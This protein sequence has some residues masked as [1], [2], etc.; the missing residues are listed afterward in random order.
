MSM[1]KTTFLLLVPFLGACGPLSSRPGEDFRITTNTSELEFFQHVGPRELEFQVSGCDDFSTEV[2]SPGVAPRPVEPRALGDGRFVASLPI[3]SL[4]SPNGYCAYS[5]ERPYHTGVQLRVTCRQDGRVQA[6]SLGVKYVPAW[7]MTYR[8]RGPVDAVFGSG[9]SERFFEVGSGWLNSIEQEKP[10]KDMIAAIAPDRAPY[11]TASGHTVKLAAGCPIGACGMFWFDAP[12]RRI[13]TSAGLVQVFD[14]Q[15]GVLVSNV[16]VPSDR[17]DF[18]TEG[19]TSVLV[20]ATTG[21]TFLTRIADDGTAATTFLDGEEPQGKTG[22]LEGTRVF[23]TRTAS[24]PTRDPGEERMRLRNLDGGLVFETSVPGAAR[25]P[26]QSWLAATGDAWVTIREGR[27]W[28]ST[29]E[30]RGETFLETTK[31]LSTGLQGF[32]SQT[33]EDS[34]Y[35]AAFTSEGVVLRDAAGVEVYDRSGGLRW[36]AAFAAGR[37]RG[38]LGMGES[39]AIL[40]TTGVQIFD[41]EGSLRGGLDPVPLGCGLDYYARHMAVLDAETVALA[42]RDGSYQ[43]RLSKRAP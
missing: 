11:L 36:K 33:A 28:L 9:E 18:V 10:G 25:T 32:G 5:A 41:R 2:V 38:A 29:L 26:V 22:L 7:R 24:L 19:L 4:Y 14:W 27:A 17:V 21:G 16:T 13:G 34:S 35:G 37:V 12:Q 42:G 6:Q 39:L 30:R 15:R 43:I 40:T 31:E 20:S 8:G 1:R 3:Q 23:L